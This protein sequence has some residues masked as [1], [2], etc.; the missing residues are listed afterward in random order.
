M[1]K[2]EIRRAANT[3][4][5]VKFERDTA[6][7]EELERRR[8]ASS[9]KRASS[10]AGG[11]GGG[12]GGGDG[13]DDEGDAGMQQ[14][15]GK[16]TRSEMASLLK[17]NILGG[18]AARR[19]RCKVP[20]ALE[21]G[22]NVIALDFKLKPSE[23][24]FDPAD[25]V[26]GGTVVAVARSSRLYAMGAAKDAEQGRAGWTVQGPRNLNAL[27]LVRPP[28]PLASMGSKRR[29]RDP[30]TEF[31]SEQRAFLV[32]NVGGM[33]VKQ[34]GSLVT[35]SDRSKSELGED[36]RLEAEQIGN[37]IRTQL[38]KLKDKKARA[39]ERVGMPNYDGFDTVELEARLRRRKIKWSKRLKDPGKRRLL[40]DD[41]DKKKKEKA[42]KKRAAST[43][44][45][46]KGKGKR[47]KRKS[48]R[49]K[50]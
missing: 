21:K 6:I 3:K 25:A 38:Q 30:R 8:A 1:L 22:Y 7:N 45:K 43:A 33:T 31:T 41:D 13:G 34:A 48:S 40:E 42:T 9:A 28:P 39:F 49:K 26:E 24:T 10:A 5:L 14:Q 17:E 4:T 18:I 19:E 23:I 2:E 44:A 20:S 11:G 32:A 16:L 29:V 12:G 27:V 35:L 37:W 50:K 47:A 46:K 36:L 15:A